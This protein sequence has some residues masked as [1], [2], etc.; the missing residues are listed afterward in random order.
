MRRRVIGTSSSVAILDVEVRPEIELRQEPEIDNQAEIQVSLSAICEGGSGITRLYI[1][2][3]TA[4]PLGQPEKVIEYVTADRPEAVAAFPASQE[5]VV[6]SNPNYTT[7]GSPNPSIPHTKITFQ[8]IQ[9]YQ[10]LWFS[11]DCIQ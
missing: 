6:E 2:E 3:T 10:K 4:K 8:V 1:P 5:V 9:G 11:T 7:S